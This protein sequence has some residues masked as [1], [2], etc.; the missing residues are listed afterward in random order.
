MQ[1]MMELCLWLDLPFGPVVLG[2]LPNLLC[3]ALTIQIVFL[4]L[5][6]R[7]RMGYASSLLGAALPAVSFGSWY[8]SVA[9]EAYA[10]PTCLMLLCLYLLADERR[11]ERSFL[12]VALIHSVAGPVSSVCGADGTL[13]P[14]RD[15]YLPRHRGRCSAQGAG[16]VCAD[17]GDHR[18]W[19]LRAGGNAAERCHHCLRVLLLVAGQR[20]R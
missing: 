16:A 5:R 4:F 8:Y 9:I 11:S 7:L 19:H 2:T 6:K 12:V 1:W 18:R 15:L 14:V 10:V 3:G 20:H 17:H 13:D